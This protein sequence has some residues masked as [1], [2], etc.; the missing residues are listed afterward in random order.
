MVKIYDVLTKKHMK[1]MKKY[2][3]CTKEDSFYEK[4]KSIESGGGSYVSMFTGRFIS[5]MRCEESRGDCFHNSGQGE[6]E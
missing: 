6:R 2:K 3:M 5:W 4:A 1:N